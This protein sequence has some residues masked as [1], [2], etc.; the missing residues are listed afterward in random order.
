MFSIKKDTRMQEKAKKGI[1][2]VLSQGASYCDIRIYGVDEQE[3][4]STLNG[5]LE[6]HDYSKKQGFGVRILYEGA[7]GFASSENFKDLDSIFDQSLKNAKAASRLIQNKIELYPK[8][9]Y[10]DKYD[11]PNQIDPF[12]IPI[13]EKVDFFLKMDNQLQHDR[14]TYR[15]VYGAFHKR[16]ILFLDSEGSEIEQNILNVDGRLMAFAMDKENKQ[17][18][19]SYPLYSIYDGTS[20]WESFTN[21]ALFSDHTHR[22]VEELLSVCDS[23]VCPSDKMNMI[24]LNEMMALQV[25]ETI[26][27]PL[28][29]DRILGYELSYAGGS[30][31][32]LADF[33]KLRYGS[34]KLTVRA[35]ATVPN[36][37]G[38]FGYDDDGVK[39]KNTVLIDKGILVNAIT[40]RAT[41]VE[42]NRKAGKTIFN[43]SGGTNR[44]SS[45]NRLP[46]E[47][48]TNI[49]VDFGQDGNLN[50]IIAQCENGIML[51]TPKSWSIGSNRENFHFATEIGWIIKNGK[52]DHIVR[53][54]SYKGDT[55]KFWNSLSK[56]GSKETWRMEQVFNCGKGQP[57]QI[58]R[59]GHGIPICLF[60]NVQIGE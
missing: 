49:N 6:S 56:V 12:S 13:K 59:L 50:Q 42:A 33:G 21:P 43:E 44:A 38:S 1:D 39:S 8:K 9:V 60:S 29:L 19:R 15:V 11:S 58:M 20:G 37:A 7:W 2:K 57:N 52:V 16:N 47:R 46:I 31:V 4:F 48:M 23:P 32:Q 3:S 18:R 27:H 53:N 28:E 14:L 17:Q 10:Q 41:V 36:S 34:D 26:G 54:P 25:H 45:Y 55:L 22:I 5:T 51:D 35:D 40:S 24:L 30:H